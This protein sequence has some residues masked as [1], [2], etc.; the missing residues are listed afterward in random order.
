MPEVEAKSKVLESDTQSLLGGAP[1]IDEDTEEFVDLAEGEGDTTTETPDKPAAK[2]QKPAAAKPA[3]K[4]AVAK[5]AAEDDLPAEFKGKSLKEVVKMYQ[6]A[7][8]K[9][10]EQGT[11]LGEFRKK[12]DLVIQASLAQL[13]A[14]QRGQQPAKQEPAKEEKIDDSEFFANPQQAIAKAVENHPLIKELRKSQ[15]QLAANQQQ[16]VMESNAERF[17][18]AHPDAEQIIGDPEFRAWV[19]K[20]NVRKALLARAHQRYDFAAGDEVFS[21]WKELKSLRKPAADPT[22]DAG[23]AD[24]DPAKAAASEAGRALAAARAAKRAAAADAAAAPTSGGGDAGG[25]KKKVFRR[26]DIL[27]L[28]EEQP[29]RYAAMADEILQAYKEKRVR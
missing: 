4:P 6:D 12:A 2:E 5:P 21:T 23:A 29:E 16:R 19:E 25:G 10:G 15:G 8:R 13:A 9:I 28:M 17:N 7:H 18:K 22:A 1:E 3:A 11:E 24:A 14:Q 20:S 27:R 26:A